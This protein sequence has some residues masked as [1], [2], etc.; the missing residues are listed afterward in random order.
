MS[1]NAHRQ[2]TGV[3]V[4]AS[5]LGLAPLEEYT[6]VET[7]LLALPGSTVMRI[8][9]EDGTSYLTSVE[10]LLES[11]RLGEVVERFQI[12]LRLREI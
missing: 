1:T 10:R 8:S 9:L 11:S 7:W 3:G 4:A 2:I 6:S 12:Q 5:G